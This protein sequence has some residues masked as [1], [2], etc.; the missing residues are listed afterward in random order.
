MQQAIVVDT[1]ILFSALL[2][3]NS[4]FRELLLQSDERFFLCEFVLVEIF[5]RK[6]KIVRASQLTEDEIAEVYHLLLKRIE[7]YKE[8]SIAPENR[9]SAY[10]L[11]RDVD[12]SDTP[13]I[14]LTLELNGLLWTGDKKLKEGLKQKGFDR[15]F[16][17]N[18]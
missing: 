7:L 14:A 12:E 2:S 3:S 4:R 9:N 15:F 11:C 13:H 17:P 1:N 6:E 8:D 16:K 18:L 10:A 5:K